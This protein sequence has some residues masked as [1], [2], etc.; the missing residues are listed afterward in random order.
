MFALI[1]THVEEDQTD[2]WSKYFKDFH[3]IWQKA[4]RTSIHGR[5]SGG[6][7]CG[8]KK[9]LQTRGIKHIFVQE[10]Q[11]N[12]IRI[13]TS[14]TNFTF[15]PVYIRGENWLNE[16]EEMKEICEG[17]SEGHILLAGD[18]NVRIGNLQ[19]NLESCF[20][21]EFTAGMDTR[22]SK[23]PII[24][25]K[26][27][28][29]IEFCEDNG[30]L[31]LNGRT[32][33][34]EEGHFTYVSTN[35]SS[36]NDLAAISYNGL[37]M[38]KSLEVEEK[39]WSDHLP[40][41]I[42]IEVEQTQNTAK[43]LNMLP[44]LLWKNE[45]MERY[46]HRL[47]QN[48][49]IAKNSNG[50]NNLT[51]LSNVIQKSAINTSKPNTYKSAWYNSRCEKARI[52]SFEYLNKFRRSNTQNDK[53]RYL[54]AV[55]R[56][57]AM[58][59]KRKIDYARELEVKLSKTSDAK[60]WWSTAKQ[61][62]GQNKKIGANISAVEFKIYFN[63]LLNKA[64]FANDIEYAVCFRTDL[65]LDR[66]IDVFDVQEMLNKTKENKAPGMDRVPYEFLK[67]ASHEFLTE[68]AHQY[69]RIYE[70]GQLDSII[71]ESVIFPIYKK[72]DVN[73]PNNYRGISFM[74]TIAKV[75]MGVLNKRLKKWVGDNKILNEFQAGFRTGY[76]TVDNIY[77]LASIVHLKLTEKR[78]V[79][80]FFVDF[81]AAF[82][83]VPRQL[84]IYKLHEMGMPTKMV[85]MIKNIYQS[86]KS[87]IWTGDEV[88]QEFNTYTGVRQGCLLSPLLFTLYLNDLHD[89]LEGGLMVD[90][91]NI[92]VLLYADDIV[93]L[94][95]E[96]EVLQSMI[97][98]LEKY[99]KQWNM[100]V[101]LEKSKIMVFRNGGRL[102][103]NEKWKYLN[104]E[105][106]I[107]NEYCYL[108]VVLTPKMTFT[109][110][111]EYRNKRSKICINATWQS[112]INKPQV[113]LISKWKIFQSVCKTTQSYAAQV[114][115][116]SW[117][118]DVDMLQ[119]YFLK[120]VLKQPKNM[121]NYILSLET[122]VPDNHFYTL[123]LHMDYIYNTLFKYENTRLPHKLSIKIWNKRIFWAI[124]MESLSESTNVLIENMFRTTQDWKAT[125][126]IL[127]NSLKSQSYT[128][129]I[130]KA[131]ASESR[132]YRFLNP[133]VGIEYMSNIWKLEKIAV[134]MRTRADVLPLNGNNFRNEGRTQ[135][136]LCNMREVESLQHFI[137]RCPILQEFRVRYLGSFYLDEREIIQILNGNFDDGWERLYN[138]VRSAL[139]YRNCIIREQF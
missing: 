70:T 100:V 134:I 124:A 20:E 101:N 104:Q 76:S 47:N 122:D 26:G 33:G 74:N 45:Q 57:K 88:S 2:S 19:Q 113:S 36:V 4:E 109:K 93:I 95:D 82:D 41:K 114:W 24:N 80:A 85:N 96:R 99:C 75:L 126:T 66:E 115:G 16:F 98:N 44:K 7:V 97:Y 27:K 120:K 138:Y 56:Y 5:A 48:L 121:P 130:E 22:V 3:L 68:L 90:E 63:T 107:V 125:A 1:E 62:R 61:I 9:D 127:V 10:N 116:F 53:E 77:S 43:P 117:F 133:G 46:G 106:E 60:Q 64:Q 78:K 112:L 55:K 21:T 131:N 83:M 42:E 67:H 25:T 49:L 102:A 135:C 30:L 87:M 34:D 73:T 103:T 32:A 123:K 51:D 119:R 72:G 129:K 17:I 11:S 71:E 12:L 59:K 31:I 6:I 50:I 69:N 37:G 58:C 65:E 28:Q 132:F 89:W 79:Y 18:I 84:L 52:N 23:D 39:I 118:K 108:G 13:L 29:F 81:S 110:H 8:V 92:R 111:V 94:A 91:I 136:T 105:I 35:G 14:A 15:F 54:N 38:I 137:A 128:E 40:L 139:R 86:T